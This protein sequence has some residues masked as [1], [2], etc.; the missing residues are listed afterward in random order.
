MSHGDY[1]TTPP[2]GFTVTASNDY[3]PISAIENKNKNFH[4]V[5]F[6]PEVRHTEHG[7]ELLRNFAFNVCEC[8]GNWSMQ[9]FIDMEVEKIRDLVGDKKVLLGLSGGVDSSVVGVLSK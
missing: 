5:Q 9:N 4:A 2:E 6:H 1:V 7:N 3:C 8:S